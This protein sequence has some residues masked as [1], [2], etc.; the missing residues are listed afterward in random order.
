MKRTIIHICTLLTALL[1][2]NS[3]LGQTWENWS[4]NIAGG[5]YSGYKRLTSN[6]H[7]N[8]AVYVNAGTELTIDLNGYTLT[9]NH[10]TYGHVIYNHGTLTVTDSSNL[11]SG[12]ITGGTGDRGGCLKV[13]SGAKFYFNG[14]TIQNC[15]PRFNDADKTGNQLNPVDALS[16]GAGGAVYISTGGY[17]E[18][19]G[20]NIKNCS[21]HSVATNILGGDSAYSNVGFG[22]AVFIHGC[23]NNKDYEYT[24]FILN[25]GTIE[26]CTAGAGGAVY[27]YTLADDNLGRKAVFNMYGGTIRNCKALY[28]PAPYT[29]GGGAVMVD[30]FGE[31]N[32]FGGTIEGCESNGHG[33]GVFTMGKMTMS[34]NSKII[35]CKPVGWVEVNWDNTAKK[36]TGT[37]TEN[38]DLIDSYLYTGGSLGGGLFIYGDKADVVMTS[39]EISN[40]R[41]GSG[42]GVLMYYTSRTEPG[43]AKGGKFVMNGKNAVIKENKVYGLRIGNGAG[44]YVAGSTFQFI[45][46]TIENNIA[47]RYGGGINTHHEGVILMEGKCIVRNNVAMH[48]GGISQEIG[49]CDIV[50]DS[51]G[52]LIEGNYAHG[53]GYGKSTT[54]GY[55][56]GEEGMG[57][58][59]GVFAEQGSL[60]IKRAAIKDNIATGH[61]GGVV[62]RTRE[63]NVTID[64]YIEG[65]TISGNQAMEGGGIYV[66]V[67]DVGSR[68]QMTVGTAS[69]EPEIIANE[70][71]HNGG[72][73]GL[74][75]GDITIIH[76][77]VT[78]NEAKNGGG[79]YVENGNVII[80]KGIISHNEADVN[81]GGLYVYNSTQAS[82]D[83][84]FSGGAFVDNHAKNGGGVCANGALNVK[85]DATIENNTAS[86][87]GGICLLNGAI[88]SFGDGLI[89]NNKAEGAS[90]LTT[91]YQGTTESLNG[92]GGGIFMDS[93]TKLSFSEPHNMG[94]YNNRAD[95]AADDVFAN[96]NGTEV[97]LPEVNDMMLKDF[98]APTTYLYWIE[99][100]VTGDSEYVK[101][102]NRIG[103]EPDETDKNVYRYQY[104][105]KNLKP[106]WE[107]EEENNKL[108]DYKSRYLCLALGYDQIFL[109]LIKKGLQA[110]DNVAF[111]ISYPDSDSDGNYKE[112]RKVYMYGIE[113]KDV[114]NTVCLPVGNWR[115]EESSWTSKYVPV[116]ENSSNILE[117]GS[118]YV[119]IKVVRGQ[120]NTLIVT[121]TLKEAYKDIGIRAYETHK[122][123]PMTP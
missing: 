39:G 74:N 75:N 103:N 86:N 8:G 73:I 107:L 24:T 38:G 84:T 113:G 26:G 83:I 47:R 116:F 55:V 71:T 96:G 28:T 51:D 45:E 33:C 19:N 16:I 99:D 20:G 123:N 68:A 18:M 61:G 44:V 66:N 4:R 31:F 76:G 109:K 117:T 21:T 25:S 110:G 59:G 64:A 85:I 87:G 42:G 40:N 65:G 79:V 50:L 62:L 48:G 108:Q 43:T 49:K 15:S 72:G 54:T 121:N 17:M 78:Q 23:E 27:L 120:D 30:E 94:L 95:N 101:G 100:Y 32:M 13:Y 77:K 105:L 7:I 114:V 2:A 58:G 88:M 9:G 46:G 34:G 14:G 22:G 115:I 3:V 29:H 104:A 82:K 52:I 69:S 60:T 118:Q 53:I 81:G 41:A 102:T 106:L 57:N 90:I 37:G 1:Y 10:P 5:V 93:G 91:A 111:I 92:V 80:Q 97:L 70:A 122:I 56:E 112:Y 119:V 11:K 12:I 35:N 98:D 6:V 36:W 67:N 89:F 63:E